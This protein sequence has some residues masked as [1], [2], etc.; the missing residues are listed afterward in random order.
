MKFL[1]DICKF[2]KIDYFQTLVPL[3]LS[4]EAQYYPT[5]NLKLVLS[6]ASVTTESSGNLAQAPPTLN[7]MVFASR[8]LGARKSE[9]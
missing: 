1:K 4:E 7:C 3:S 2:I 8:L 9:Y 5:Q 6:Q